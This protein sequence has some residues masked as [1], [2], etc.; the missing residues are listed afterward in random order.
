MCTVVPYLY[1]LLDPDSHS[2]NDPD[3]EEANQ[4]GSGS[5][6]LTRRLFVALP[7]HDGCGKLDVLL[8]RLAPVVLAVDGVGGGQDAGARIQRGLHARLRDRD[9]LLLHGLV[10]GHLVVQVHLVEL[11]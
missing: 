5:E 6:I 10:Y 3:P 11:V 8:E 9:G 1:G 4:C 2:L 7:R